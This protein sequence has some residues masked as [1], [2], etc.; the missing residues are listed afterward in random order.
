M[1]GPLPWYDTQ[2]YCLSHE[3]LLTRSLGD[4]CESDVD[5][6]G[7][8]VCSRG[9]CANSVAGPT[10]RP[11]TPTRTAPIR[12]TTVYVTIRPTEPSNPTCEWTGHCAGAC[13]F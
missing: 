13:C 5:C 4:P 9:E 1:D 12:T 10:V 7:D 2:S 8:L 6:D 3:E 11:T